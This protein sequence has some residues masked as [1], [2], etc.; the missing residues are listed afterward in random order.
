MGP[1]CPRMEPSWRISSHRN[2]APLDCWQERGLRASRRRSLWPNCW[3]MLS[4]RRSRHFGRN[5]PF[6]H[7]LGVLPVHEWLLWNL[8]I[9]SQ[10]SG[11]PGIRLA[12]RV[13]RNAKPGETACLGRQMIEVLFSL[14]LALA[15]LYFVV[16][17][18]VLLPAGMAE[19]RGR[20]AFGWVL[21]SL[22][23]SPIMA[24]LLLWF[25]GDGPN[26]Q[27]HSDKF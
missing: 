18:F 21:V 11:F 23:F 17:F 7:G 3:A 4:V 13:P 5:D 12:G 14:L 2:I 16:W 19:V 20:S 24:C 25:L 15:A 27:T 10:A 26:Q 9:S 22:V 6:W 8:L 1:R